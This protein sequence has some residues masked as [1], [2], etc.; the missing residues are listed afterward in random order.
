MQ[1]VVRFSITNVVESIRVAVHATATREEQAVTVVIEL[2]DGARSRQ[3]ART[4]Q[5]HISWIIQSLQDAE[6]LK[7]DSIGGFR[8]AQIG[9]VIVGLRSIRVVRIVVRPV[10]AAKL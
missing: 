7:V 8:Q 6:V 9:D 4:R 2:E 1:Q 5:A 3:P 10:R